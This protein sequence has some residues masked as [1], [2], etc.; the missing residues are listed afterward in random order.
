MRCSG[1]QF[2][3]QD[4][5]TLDERTGFAR[6][7]NVAICFEDIEHILDDRKLMKSITYC[8]CPGGILL[9]TTPNFCLF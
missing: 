6:N 5:R 8:L 2:P 9:L 1:T 7:F 4:V 3:I